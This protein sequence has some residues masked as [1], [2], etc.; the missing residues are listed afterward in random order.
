MSRTIDPLQ[1][2]RDYILND[3]EIIYKSEENMLV[4]GSTKVPVN[5]KTAWIKKGGDSQYTIGTLW[6]FVVNRKMQIRDYMFHAD[7]SGFEK[8]YLL[9]KNRITDYYEG[10]IETVPEIDQ[11]L[12]SETLVKFGKVNQAQEIEYQGE[13]RPADSIGSKREFKALSKKEEEKRMMRETKESNA[14]REKKKEQEELKV[15]DYLIKN[16]KKI[17]SKNSILQA[18]GKSFA[19]IYALS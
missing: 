11:T 9:D 16:E 18:P 2:L 3:K 6:F 5:T 17:V 13:D 4:F 10:K 8:I 19:Q 12:I 15:M 1:L 14:E 7:Q